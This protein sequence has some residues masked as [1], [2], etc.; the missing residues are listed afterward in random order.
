VLEHDLSLSTAKRRMSTQFHRHA[1][2]PRGLPGAAWRLVPPHQLIGALDPPAVISVRAPNTGSLVFVDRGVAGPGA[3]PPVLGQVQVSPEGA[4]DQV[5]LGSSRFLAER[6]HQ[7]APGAPEG[8]ARA[9]GKNAPQ[10]LAHSRVWLS[11]RRRARFCRRA[12]S[13]P[14]AFLFYTSYMR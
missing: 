9:E 5:G 10:M 7:R 14:Q 3:R 4:G 8:A 2:P 13:T 1:P 6:Q 12:P 11:T